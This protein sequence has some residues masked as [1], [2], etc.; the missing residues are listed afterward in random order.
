M[1]ECL[2]NISIIRHLLGNMHEASG[3]GIRSRK[4]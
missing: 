4:L 1:I 2:V 3:T